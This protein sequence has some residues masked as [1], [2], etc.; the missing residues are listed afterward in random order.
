MTRYYARVRSKYAMTVSS[1]NTYT[2]ARS[3]KEAI[4]KLEKRDLI[5][6][7]ISKN[8]PLLP[9]IENG[10]IR[11]LRLVDGIRMAA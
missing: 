9:F 11:N 7:A 1:F 10:I 8:K 5:V 3:M 2:N 4:E 6:Y